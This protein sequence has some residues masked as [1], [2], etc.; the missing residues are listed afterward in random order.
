MINNC[1]Q[2]AYEYVRA[3][4]LSMEFM[5]GET[6]TDSKVASDLNISRTPVREAF[7][8]LENEGLLISEMRRGWRVYSMTLKDIDDIFDIKCEVE[9]L[10]ARKAA[11]DQN[12][13]HH[14]VLKD[15][16]TRMKIASNED[17]LGA[18]MELDGSLH[19]LLYVM[20]QNERAE[21][22][23]RNLNDQWHRLRKGFITM[24][25]RLD[26][27]TNE[28]ELVISAIIAHDADRAQQAMKDHLNDV[29]HGLIKVLVAMILPYA[30][31]GL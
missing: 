18:W 8:R 15:I 1:Q 9:G 21:R 4:I 23:I 7:Q 31:D 14:Q 19:H 26:V 24:S 2:Q 6:L 28:H 12:E 30:R 25:G 20:A 29:R 11:L 16:L 17:D 13:E 5:P 10:I 27:A 3:K 22:I